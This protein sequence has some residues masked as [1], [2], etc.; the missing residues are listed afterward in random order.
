MPE[1]SEVNTYPSRNLADPPVVSMRIIP[2][3]APTG[4]WCPMTAPSPQPGPAAPQ[5]SP[6]APRVRLPLRTLSI[7]L[8][9]I[10]GGVGAEE[11]VVHAGVPFGHAVITG[12]VAFA[13]IF[14]FLDRIID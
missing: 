9:A 1:T 3:A 11:L 6:P 2:A 8:V 7:L 5:D 14:L 13:G 12:F 4:W 10:A